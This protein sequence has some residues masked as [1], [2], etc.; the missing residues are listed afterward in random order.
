LLLL[1]SASW[2]DVVGSSAMRVMGVALIARGSLGTSGLIGRGAP[3]LYEYTEF[4]RSITHV[5]PSRSGA[6]TVRAHENIQYGTN[7]SPKA[8]AR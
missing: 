2:L 5:Q 3:I 7:G 6:R 4:R 8:K 1:T